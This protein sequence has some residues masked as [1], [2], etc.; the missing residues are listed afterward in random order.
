MARNSSLF[1][2]RE[3]IRTDDPSSNFALALIGAVSQDESHSISK[4]VAMGYHERFSRGK[5]NLGN[6]R[7]LGYDTN[8]RKENWCRTGMRR[9]HDALSSQNF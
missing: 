5:F 2:E 6:N 9:R 4:N 1:F 3:H 7:I 8:K